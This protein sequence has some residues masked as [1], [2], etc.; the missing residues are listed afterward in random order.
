M[1]FIP[2]KKNEV[3]ATHRMFAHVSSLRTFHVEKKNERESELL[4]PATVAACVC[5]EFCPQGGVLLA[6]R[7]VHP[8]PDITSRQRSLWTG[9]NLKAT[10][11]SRSLSLGVDRPLGPVYTKRQRQSCDNSTMTLAILFSLKSMETLE[12][13]L[14]PHSG[15]TPLFSMRTESQA[16]SQSCRSIHADAWCKW[17][18]R[19]RWSKSDIACRCVH[20]QSKL[21]FTLSSH[22][23]NNA[24]SL[25]LY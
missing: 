14:Q 3:P 15:V 5:Q 17:A 16:S 25:S 1:D 4:P 20:R 24:L 8:L 10:P 6:P 23:E 11:F 22:G 13:G 18:F 2:E 21:M 9:T 7:V 19:V 12:N